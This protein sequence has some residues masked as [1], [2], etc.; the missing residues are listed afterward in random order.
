M[1]QYGNLGVDEV[2]GGLMGSTEVRVI[3]VNEIQV[4]IQG[5]FVQTIKSCH[6]YNV[7]LM[8]CTL[9]SIDEAHDGVASGWPV[10]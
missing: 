8:N 5:V 4:D 9:G 6:F 1:W 2:H 3:I 10:V 7:I